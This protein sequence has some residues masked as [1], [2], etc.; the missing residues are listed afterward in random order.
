MLAWISTSTNYPDHALPSPTTPTILPAE[1]NHGACSFLRQTVHSRQDR[2][3]TQGA[4]P[5]VTFRRRHQQYQ[6][7]GKGHTMTR[8]LCCPCLGACLHR[9]RGRS[10]LVANHARRV[11]T[12]YPARIVRAPTAPRFRRLPV[13]LPAPCRYH[14][15][16]RPEPSGGCPA[17]TARSPSSGTGRRRRHQHWSPSRLVQ[18]WPNSF[19]RRRGAPASPLPS[20][21]QPA[22]TPP[23]Q[24]KR[25]SMLMHVDLA[26]QQ[27]QLPPEV[28][29]ALDSAAGMDPEK[30]A[31]YHKA[32]QDS[33]CPPRQHHLRRFRPPNAPRP[34]G[35]PALRPLQARKRP[36]W[37]R[38]LRPDGS[39]R[40][41]RAGCPG[42]PSP[43]HA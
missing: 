26:A 42:D 16:A 5:S 18:H 2:C 10:R 43:H 6:R 7:Y 11:S 35:G 17:A 3:T 34:H 23:T 40:L 13:G 30:R 31:K 37:H 29:L 27:P 15:A 4:T 9:L 33:A 22:F 19:D 20:Q 21:A 38:L 36:G 14:Q 39:V 28:Y 41:Q 12:S 24:K 25:P 32:C 8:A 1:I